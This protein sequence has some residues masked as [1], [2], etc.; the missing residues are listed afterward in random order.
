MAGI[1]ARLLVGLTSSAPCGEVFAA[2]KNGAKGP[3][4]SR[5]RTQMLT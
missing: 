4:Q 3:V 2:N 5:Y 1:A